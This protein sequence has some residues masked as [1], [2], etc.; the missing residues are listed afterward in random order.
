MSS[1]GAQD[2]SNY[3]PGGGSSYGR[4]GGGG[5]GDRDCYK[6]SKPGHFARECPEAGGGGGGGGRSDNSNKVYVGNLSFS[7]DEY[8]LKEAFSAYGEVITCTVVTDRDT[9]RPRGFGFVTFSN[10]NEV[11]EAIDR[12]NGRELD[13]RDIR[14]NKAQDKP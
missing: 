12:G 2:S 9:G 14:V 3:G 11:D 10:S 4:S 8:G 5:G 1:Y 6:C 13:G 7:T